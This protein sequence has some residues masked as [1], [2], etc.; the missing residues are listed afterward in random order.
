MLPKR[1][2]NLSQ[3]TGIMSKLLELID[4]PVKYATA[5]ERI[6]NIANA[7]I[8][9]RLRGLPWGDADIWPRVQLIIDECLQKERDSRGHARADGKQNVRQKV[10]HTCENC[11]RKDHSK[12]DCPSVARAPGHQDSRKVSRTTPAQGRNS[13]RMARYN[14]M[15]AMEDIA[16]KIYCLLG[17]GAETNIFPAKLARKH[18]LVL[19]YA[20]VQRVTSFNN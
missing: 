12:R 16:G 5:A 11:G 8:Q 20:N 18:N 3:F 13:A 15:L 14:I 7:Q 2:E 9:S 17:T 6:F 4:D 10:G 19:R 1:K